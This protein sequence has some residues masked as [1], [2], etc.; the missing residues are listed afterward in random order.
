MADKD[1]CETPSILKKRALRTNLQKSATYNAINR[2]SNISIVYGR[3]R[4]K[5]SCVWLWRGFKAFSGIGGTPF[6]NKPKRQKPIEHGTKVQ[7]FQDLRWFAM[8]IIFARPSRGV[9]QMYLVPAT[10]NRKNLLGL[11]NFVL[12]CAPSAVGGKCSAPAECAD[13]VWFGVYCFDFHVIEYDQ[14][15]DA[16]VPTKKSCGSGGAAALGALR[17]YLCTRHYPLCKCFAWI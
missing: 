3:T 5:I 14:L 16:K 17:K 8:E 2:V 7:F 1:S 6:R 12:S 13:F 11:I 10:D 9:K 4:E 15:I